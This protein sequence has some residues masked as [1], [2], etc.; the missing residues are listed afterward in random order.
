MYKI[1]SECGDTLNFLF[2]TDSMDYALGYMDAVAASP[3]P[4]RGVVC[5]VGD[6]D[7]VLDEVP[8]D[9]AQRRGAFGIWQAP[10]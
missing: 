1:Y 8:A 4:R 10:E 2:S 6:G 3:T 9:G 7:Y 5:L